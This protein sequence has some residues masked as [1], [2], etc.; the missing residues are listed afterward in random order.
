[1]NLFLVVNENVSLVISRQILTDISSQLTQLPDDVSKSISHY[2]L[3]K[4]S[5]N[6]V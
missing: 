2:I 6:V 5:K 3:D 1:M 4:V